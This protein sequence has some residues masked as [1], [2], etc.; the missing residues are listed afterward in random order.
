[1]GWK[2]LKERFGIGHIVQVTS[3]GIVIGS[4]YVSDLV[5]I[6]PATGKVTENSTFSGFLREHYPALLS[7][8]ADEILSAIN[9]EDTFSTSTPVYTYTGGTII[10]KLC[11][12]PGYPNVTHD[13]CL[14][15]ENTYSTDKSMVVRWAKRNAEAGISLI[16]RYIADTEKRLA[17]QRDELE[18][19]ENDLADLDAAFP[20]LVAADRS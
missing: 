19:S 4:G 13:G 1:M 10:E 8:S 7:S 18:K 20:E 6:N 2:T 17:E 15:Y 3:A 12:K 9:A 16:T 5:T 14:M 11:E